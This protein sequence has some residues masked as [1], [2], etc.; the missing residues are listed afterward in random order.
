VQNIFQ[1]H[2][3][4]VFLSSATLEDRPVQLRPEEPMNKLVVSNVLHRPLR[5]LISIFAVAVEVVMIL[6]ITALTLGM[7]NGTKNRQIGVGM[8]MFVRPPNSTFLAGVSGA[9]APIK[10]ADILRKLPHVK[11]V[12]PVIA[13]FTTANTVET[14]YGIDFPS[15]DALRPFVFLSGGPFQGPYDAIVDDYF[16]RNDH[17]YKVGDTIQVLGKPFKISGIVEHG[18]GGRKFIPITTMGD[19]IGSEGKASMFDI[20]ADDPKNIDVIRREILNTPGMSEYQVQSVEEYLSLMTPEHLPG[21]TKALDTVITIAVIIGFLAIF[22]SMYTAV[23]ERTR[24]IGI[25]KS[26]GA[27]KG[28]IIHAVLRE[29]L[30]I[31]LVGILVGIGMTYGIRAFM[32]IRFPTLDFLLTPEW[33]IRGT[34]I[35]FGGGILGAFYPALKAARKDPIDA[36]AYE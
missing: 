31:T 6:S 19:L 5:T 14:I 20:K 11:V 34:V 8:D 32:G 24:E 23:M 9:P 13:Q 18:K 16:A 17:G 15:Y 7:L 21:L 33:L 22:Q 27:S 30:L 10:I 4:A 35:A 3:D 28:Y 29:A 25:L 36:L 2:L 26:L 12:A 1:I